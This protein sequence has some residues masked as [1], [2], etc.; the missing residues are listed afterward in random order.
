MEYYLARK[1]KEILE[2]PSL[3]NNMGEPWGNCA[4]WDR[5]RQ[6]LYIIVRD[7]EKQSS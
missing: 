4:K 2:I 7:L 1:N 5:K 3:N 6:I